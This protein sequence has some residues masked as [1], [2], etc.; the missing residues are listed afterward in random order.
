M[1]QRIKEEWNSF[2]KDVV[3]AGAHHVQRQE[4][5]RAFYAGAH[6]ILCQ[7]RAIG[8][9]DAVSELDG[10]RILEGLWQESLRFKESVLRGTN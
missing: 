10:V 6:A 4:M 3:P 9:D 1:K 7:V 8:E 2:D 5:K